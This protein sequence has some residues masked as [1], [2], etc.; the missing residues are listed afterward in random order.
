VNLYQRNDILAEL[1]NSKEVNDAIKKMHPKELQEDLKS[2]VFLILAE[3]DATKLIDLYEKKQIK[4]YM[5]RIMLN[6]VQ[7]TDKKFYGKYRNFVEYI[8]VEKEDVKENDLTENITNV[9]EQLYWYQKEIL[10]LYTYQFN[11]NAKELSRQTGIPY[12]SII[13]TLNQIKKE[14]KQQLRK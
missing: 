8:E 6:L 5:V 3:L 9:F 12:M 13:R 1:W 7:S 14:L 11:K 2:E 4:F 10:R